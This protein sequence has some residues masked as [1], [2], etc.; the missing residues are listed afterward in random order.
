MQAATRGDGAVGQDAMPAA[1]HTNGL[2]LRVAKTEPFTVRGELHITKVDFATLNEERVAAGKAAM[3]TARNAAAGAA[4]L[5]TGL[6]EQRLSF[7]AFQLIETDARIAVPEHSQ[8]MQ[9][10]EEWGF[11]TVRPFSARG[12]TIEEALLLAEALHDERQALPY[13]TDGCVL[14]VDSFTVGSPA[15]LLL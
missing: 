7:A 3:V 1:L 14:K 9:R 15:W 12:R 13:D 11:G 4:R 5:T 2:P 8:A 10:L 6:A